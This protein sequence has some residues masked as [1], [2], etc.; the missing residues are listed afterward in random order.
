MSGWWTRG[1]VA[2]TLVGG[3]MM[4]LGLADE[5]R[6]NFAGS[7]QV[8]YLAVP[9][10]DVARRQ[11]LD[12][13][14]TELSLKLAVDLGESVSASV[15]VCFGC[16]GFELGMAFFDVRLVDELYVRAGRFTPAF[17]EFPLR[18]DPANHRTSD[19]PLP[20]DMGRMLRLG[21]WNM[22]ILPAPWV[23][24]GVEVGGTHFFGNRS[25]VDYSLYAIMGPKAGSEAADFDFV[26][27]RTPAS[28]YVDNNSRPTVGARLSGTLG[29]GDG[30]SI[31][32]GLS[33]MGGTYDPE[34]QLSFLFAG[35]DLVVR[36]GRF[37][38]RSE[39]LWRRT[40][41]ALGADPEA[42]F[43]YAVVDDFFVK[44]GFN[45]EIE[46]PV[47]RFDLVVRWD[48]LRRRGNVLVSSPLRSE[49]AVLR[50]TVALTYRLASSLRLK[51]SAELYDFSDFDDE[52]ALH[53]GLV[54]PF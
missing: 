53:L 34:N 19:K 5:P 1:L 33:A 31:A 47:G 38:W 41:M 43:R 10:D 6:R 9:T 4:G 25:Q 24:T 16:H 52:L 32:L 17:G 18:H 29:F 37:F 15:K 35:A 51:A 14:T 40:Q 54:A 7:I 30:S 46:W 42:R 22:G 21:E 49:S 44:D 36:L 23:D 50:Y 12:G 26:S 39:V 27:S 11:V 2:A 48:G 3:G 13:A 28:Y 20:Y 8:D 45:T